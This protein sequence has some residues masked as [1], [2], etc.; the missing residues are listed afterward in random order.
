MKCNN[1]NVFGVTE[2]AE[3]EI[4]NIIDN[5]ND[6]AAGWD[7][8]KPK[9]IKSIK[10]SVKI[11]LTH[12]SNLSFTSGVFP[13]ELKIAN[14]VP[15]FKADDEMVFTNYRPMSVLPVFSKL[16]ERLMYNRLIDYINE[17]HILFE[18]QFG[19]QK[20]KSTFM[21]LI[22]L[23]VKI[24]A[25]LENWDFVIGVFLDFSKAFDIVDHNILLEKLDFYG[26]K[27][28]TYK[29][30]E[31]YLWERKQY[32]TYNGI[33]SDMEVIKCGVPQGSILGPLLFF[34]LYQWPSHG[35]KCL[36]SHIVCWWYQ[37]FYYRKKY[38]WNVH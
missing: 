32:V 5:F 37:Y 33:T 22:V 17:N 7:E 31:D 16:L 12:I 18:Y 15:I 14:V 6:S 3:S 10:N 27:G 8:F 4:V 19:F 23:L 34:T 13:K 9:V 35:V 1:T 26:I 30:F 28:V 20:G 38:R 2:V 36:L 24:S 11:P 25:A 29:W 21:A